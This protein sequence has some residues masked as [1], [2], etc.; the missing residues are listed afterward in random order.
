MPFAIS[1]THLS[2]SRCPR[3]PAMPTTVPPLAAS[4]AGYPAGPRAIDDRQALLPARR[5]RATSGSVEKGL[6]KIKLS[7]A[8]ITQKCNPTRKG[9]MRDRHDWHEVEQFQPVLPN[10]IVQARPMEGGVALPSQKTGQHFLKVILPSQD[11][12]QRNGAFLER[13]Q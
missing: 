4:L 9:K 6:Q 5:A 8:G 3:S 11:F 12:T 1:R 10:N 7:T 13:R 2:P